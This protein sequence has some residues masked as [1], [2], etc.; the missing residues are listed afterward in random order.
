MEYLYKYRENLFKK[1]VIYNPHEQFES[2]PYD[3]S[4]RTA[5]GR[6]AD[7]I[8]RAQRQIEALSLC[9]EWDYFGTFTLSPSYGD[10]GDLDAFRRDFTQF[11][12]DVR[13]RTGQLIA[14]VLVPELHKNAK[15]WHI[16]GLLKGLDIELLRE[17]TLREK[18]P[19]YI[20]D[21]LKQGEVIYDWSGYRERFG[22]VDIEPLRCRDAAARYITKYITKETALATCKALQSGK[23][24]YFASLG[25]N[26]PEQ[27]ENAPEWASEAFSKLVETSSYKW[28]YGEVH[29]YEC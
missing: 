6:T 14:Y 20:R 11:I 4:L 5:E 13:K 9:N 18:L 12:R 1:V 25:L 7:N 16:H 21:K 17:F 19:K 29:W 8:R 23:H 27:I 10:R 2:R 24:L 22:W 26:R 15:G 3:A 28:D